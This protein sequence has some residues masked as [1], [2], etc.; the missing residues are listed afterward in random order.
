MTEFEE[1]RQQT[2]V[3]STSMV[4]MEEPLRQ[5][6][7]T[8][9][10]HGHKEALVFYTDNCCNDAAF[11]EKTIP[12]L[13]KN[14]DP[15]PLVPL[16]TNVYV[17]DYSSYL[18]RRDKDLRLYDLFTDTVSQIEKSASSGAKVQPQPAG[19]DCEWQNDKL[20][21]MQISFKGKTLCSFQDV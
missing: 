15:P 7:A 9:A 11:L 21:V 2:L 19:L 16:P 6:I 20:L 17:I 5:M 1:I 3:Q 12:S 4:E 18:M 14:C 10:A 13:Q 8:R